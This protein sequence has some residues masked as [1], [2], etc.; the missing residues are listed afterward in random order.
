M[1]RKKKI[2]VS[3]VQDIHAEIEKR[4][5]LSRSF[6]EDDN[7]YAFKDKE[8]N[9]ERLQPTCIEDFIGN[10][11]NGMIKPCS[12]IP[13]EYKDKWA[14]DNKLINWN[15]F[16]ELSLKYFPK[17]SIFGGEIDSIESIIEYEKKNIIPMVFQENKQYLYDANKKLLEIGAGYFGTYKFLEEELGRQ[18]VDENYY[19]LDVVKLSDEVKNLYIGDGNRFPGELLTQNFDCVFSVNC[20]Q[21]LTTEQRRNYYRDIHASLKKDTGTFILFWYGA[22]KFD[23][24]YRKTC[25]SFCIET[26]IQTD[27]QILDDLN[28]VF[29]NIVYL[30]P[31]G[32]FYTK[33]ICMR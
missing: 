14:I 5:I 20:F 28:E 4:L 15:K 2:V 13:P 25:K 18:Y 16:W 23:A 32:K 7:E 27:G 21:H 19:A 30:Q 11:P 1:P 3:E 29:K 9:L 10:S 6:F 12:L 24:E 22:S 31:N 17:A 33:Y 8:V 26:E